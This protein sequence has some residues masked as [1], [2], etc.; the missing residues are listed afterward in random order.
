VRKGIQ[1]RLEQLEKQSQG[2]LSRARL[3]D[4][5]TVDVAHEDRLEALLGL[6]P[7]DDEEVVIHPLCNILRQLAPEQEDS[8][9]HQLANL[10]EA[11]RASA[12]AVREEEQ[13]GEP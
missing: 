11:F 12:A 1:A 2:L 10:L 4:G 8:T 13:N 5:S 6:L 9:L 7:D 3:L